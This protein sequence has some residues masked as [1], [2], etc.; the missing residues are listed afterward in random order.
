MRHSVGFSPGARQLSFNTVNN[1]WTSSF[2]GMYKNSTRVECRRPRGGVSMATMIYIQRSGHGDSNPFESTHPGS[3]S[4]SHKGHQEVEHSESWTSL[5]WVCATPHLFSIFTSI[6]QNG[7]TR[8]IFISLARAWARKSHLLARNPKMRP[9]NGRDA[10]ERSTRF[11]QGVSVE[12]KV[13]NVLGS[14]WLT[15]SNLYSI[16]KASFWDYRC[17]FK[18]RW[19][20]WMPQALARQRRLA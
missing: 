1:I 18:E 7:V 20:S 6:E 17:H 4:R 2:S 12:H 10:S 13:N 9:T 16:E 3:R 15:L 19:F 5:V 14:K 8:A 11:H